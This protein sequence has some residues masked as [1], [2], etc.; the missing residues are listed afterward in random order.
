MANLDRG[1]L[2]GDL[3]KWIGFLQGNFR[4]F[5]FAEADELRGMIWRH[6]AAF[7][8]ITEA[9]TQQECH[10][11]EFVSSNQSRVEASRNYVRIGYEVVKL[12]NLSSHSRAL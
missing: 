11:I 2:I 4:D 6:S 3:A 12:R 9:K 5:R 10:V 8:N 1:P 7:H